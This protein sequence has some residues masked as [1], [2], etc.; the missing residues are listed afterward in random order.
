MSAVRDI[1]TLGAVF[2]NRYLWAIFNI[3]GISRAWTKSHPFNIYLNREHQ[4]ATQSVTITCAV[5]RT[6]KN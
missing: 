4:C 5:Q 3:Q 6:T 1:K 2:F